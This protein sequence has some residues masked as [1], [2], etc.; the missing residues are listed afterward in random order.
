MN[1]AARANP[2]AAAVTEVIFAGAEEAAEAG[3]VAIGDG[4]VGGQKALAGL[5]EG[6]H[7]APPVSGCQSIRMRAKG[8]YFLALLQLWVVS[9]FAS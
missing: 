7:L 6:L 4:E 3:P 9:Q 8:I 2:E 1:A 5:V